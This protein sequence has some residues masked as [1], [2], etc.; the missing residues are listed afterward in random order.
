MQ[1]E[2]SDILSYTSKDGRIQLKIPVIDNTIWLTKSDIALL[3][4]KSRS[5]IA[6]HIQA[7]LSKEKLKATK[8]CRNFEQTAPDGTFYQMIYYNLDLIVAVGR[9]S[10]SPQMPSFRKWAIT[11]LREHLPIDDRKFT[12]PSQWNSYEELLDQLQEIRASLKP[13]Q[14]KLKRLF[15]LSF[16]YDN[17]SF[18]DIRNKLVLSVT[19][20]NIPESKR[21][22]KSLFKE[23]E[24]RYLNYV[25]NMFL[26]IAEH[27]AKN[28]RVI[29]MHQW[30]ELIGQFLELNQKPQ[31]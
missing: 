10:R 20:R 3:F 17:I 2:S 9:Y 18:L 5:T 29:T 6:E 14:Q 26:D 19:G 31:A 8:V 11:T 28:N 1:Q 25:A 23:E 12:A 21:I 15:S 16:D 27:K 22:S 24:I 30:K 4:Q 7:I 13:F